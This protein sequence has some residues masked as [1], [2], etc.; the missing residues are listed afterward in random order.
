MAQCTSGIKPRGLLAVFALVRMPGGAGD[1]QIL[2]TVVS[3]ILPI[4]SCR[5]DVSDSF[6]CI[7]P[8]QSNRQVLFSKYLLLKQNT[9]K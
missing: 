4:S 7:S 3:P 5:P 6:T 8:A 2:E 9:Y 1:L